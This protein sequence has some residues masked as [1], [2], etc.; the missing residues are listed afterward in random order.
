MKKKQ[1]WE[2][3]KFRV[4]CDL[5]AEV[6]KYALSYFWWIFEP[7][8][9]LF[10]LYI[11]F[12]VFFQGNNQPHYIPFLFCG[13]VPW[14]WFNKSVTSGME[15]ILNGRQ[16]IRDTYIPKYFFPTVSIIQDLVKEM[17]VLLILI[18]VLFISGVYPTKMWVLLP[19]ILVLQLLLIA[20]IVYFISIIVPY[21]LDL[22]QIISTLMQIVMFGAGTFYDFKTMPEEYHKL[23]LLNPIALL[24]NMYRDILIYNNFISIRS[25][26]YILLYI[27]LFGILGYFA[28]K[29]LDK[30]VPKVLFR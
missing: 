16:I 7:G 3:V 25:C 20:S 12:G 10:I 2:L 22:K 15:S 19:V 18:I 8:L 11:V 29:H 9:H 5:K 30:E 28:H 26:V 24:I 17:L 14:F 1:F 23:F 6:D 4:Q 27:V 21:F 13:I